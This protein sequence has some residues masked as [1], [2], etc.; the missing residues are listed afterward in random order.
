M[1]VDQV[2]PIIDRIAG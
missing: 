1:I 2:Q